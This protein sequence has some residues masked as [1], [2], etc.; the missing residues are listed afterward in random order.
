MNSVHLFFSPTKTNV[1]QSS[2]RVVC[3]VLGLCLQNCR[4]L[5][6]LVKTHFKKCIYYC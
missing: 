3:P 4:H 5:L 2:F 6:I 1:M